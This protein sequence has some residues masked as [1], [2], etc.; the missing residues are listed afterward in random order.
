M[1]YVRTWRHTLHEF[2]LRKDKLQHA[3][4]DGLDQTTHAKNKS[5]LRMPV[6]DRL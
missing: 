5:T 3:N 4:S 2:V 1:Y 6:S